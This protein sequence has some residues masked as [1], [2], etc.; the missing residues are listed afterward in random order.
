LTQ[1][2]SPGYRM[3]LEEALNALGVEDDALGS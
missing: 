3:V 1:D 2:P